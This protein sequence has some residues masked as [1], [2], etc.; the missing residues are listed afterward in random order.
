V[1][2]F[3]KTRNKTQKDGEITGEELAAICA[4]IANTPQTKPKKIKT[5]SIKGVPQSPWKLMG[6]KDPVVYGMQ[7]RGVRGD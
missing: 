5:K 6:T 4:A 2:L 1:W 3:K 7:R